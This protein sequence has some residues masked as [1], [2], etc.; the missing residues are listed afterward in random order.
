MLGG[1][2]MKPKQLLIVYFSETGHTEAMAKAIGQGA[3]SVEGVDVLVKLADATTN[4]D[5]L[6]A[7]GIVLGSPTWF[8][9]PAWPL[10]RM[11]DESITIYRQLAGKAGGAFTST[12]TFVDG[13]VCLRALKDM[14]EEHRIQMVGRGVLAIGVPDEEELEYCRA[15]GRDVAACVAGHL[16]PWQT[17]N[18][19][20]RYKALYKGS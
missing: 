19:S 14:L 2:E 9:L 18:R 13:I 11:I 17:W 3:R 1:G 6:S 10:K 7:D 15:Y 8:R 4:D 12:G 16:Q 5:L 20:T